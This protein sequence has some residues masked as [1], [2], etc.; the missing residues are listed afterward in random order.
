MRHIAFA[1]LR[2]IAGT[3]SALVFSAAA[4]TA[5]ADTLSELKA[6]IDALQKKVE[7]LEKKQAPSAPAPEPAPAQAVTAGATKGSF[8]LPGSDTSITIGGYLKGDL[9]YSDK[10]AGVASQGNQFLFPSLIPVGPTAGANGK[11]QLTAH[12]R[13]SRLTIRSSTPSSFGDITTLLE[14]DFFGADGN[15]TASNSHN[16]RLRHAFGSIGNFSAGQYW[17][18]FIN[19]AAFPETV[20]FGGPV[21]EIFVRQAQ[22]RWTQPFG[23]GDWSVSAENPESLFALPTT[24]TLFRSDR[25][26]FPDLTARLRLNT[27]VGKYS[28]QVLARNIRI[29]SAAAPAA[30]ANRWGGAI[31]GAGVI[32]TI[33]KDDFRFVGTFGNVVGRYQELG[34]FADGFIDSN[35]EIQLASVISGFAA[36][37][38]FWSPTL[39]SSLVLAG[40]RARNPAATFG[41]INRKSESLHANLIWSPVSAV[42]LGAEYILGRRVVQDGRQG[43]LNRFQLS[44]QYAF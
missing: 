29:D 42:N 37:R 24:A 44:A 39:R 17:S 35:G 5:Q 25:D 43:N 34:F 14:D 11:G 9:I 8:K 16:F 32:S 40:A 13:Q 31:S 10:S 2:P 7:D 12:A 21:G 26:R 28:L 15:E 19:E 20:D 36:Y 27:D 4:A 22:A 6:Q 38:H 18:N 1:L 3:M 41:A 33:G 23:S 30:V